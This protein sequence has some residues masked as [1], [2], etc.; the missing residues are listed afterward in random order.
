MGENIN[1]FDT[2]LAICQNF[3]PQNFPPTIRTVETHSSCNTRGGSR[4]SMGAVYIIY[5][6]RGSGAS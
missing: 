4:D 2:L 3:T 5:G 6:G 1:G